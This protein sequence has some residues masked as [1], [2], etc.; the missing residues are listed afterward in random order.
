MRGVQSRMTEQKYLARFGATQALGCSLI[1]KWMKFCLFTRSDLV[2][3]GVFRASVSKELVDDFLSQYLIWLMDPMTNPD[4]K[5]MAATMA[6]PSLCVPILWNLIF[7]RGKVKGTAAWNIVKEHEKLYL[8]GDP[9][10][11]SQ[12]EYKLMFQ[13]LASRF[14]DLHPPFPKTRT[15][16]ADFRDLVGILAVVLTCILSYRAGNVMDDK[17]SPEVHEAPLEKFISYLPSTRNPSKLVFETAEKKDKSGDKVIRRPRKVVWVVEKESATLDPVKVLDKYFKAMGLDRDT[18][19]G[20]LCKALGTKGNWFLNSFTRADFTKWLGKLESRKTIHH[21]R[22]I[23]E[24]KAL[25]SRILRRTSLSNLAT[26]S[27]IQ[28]TQALAGHANMSTTST[29]YVGLEEEE[30]AQVRVARTFELL[31]LTQLFY[32]SDLLSWDSSGTR[33]L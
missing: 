6:R 21:Q 31:K 7:G 4:K 5:A 16:N 13:D 1:R 11:L 8:K 14:E 24:D 19:N 27:T 2:F 18:R 32:I 30:L 12:D 33:S 20:P 25:N 22:S 29:Y 9:L 17:V 10:R 23:P 3:H 28:E 15:G 26:V